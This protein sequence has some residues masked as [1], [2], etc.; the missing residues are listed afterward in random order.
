MKPITVMQFAS[1][2]TSVFN[3]A[4]VRYIRDERGRTFC[5][6]GYTPTI[7]PQDE[8]KPVA[9]AEYRGKRK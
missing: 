4:K 2:V 5:A 6:R 7:H 9:V 3:G 1:A 8:A